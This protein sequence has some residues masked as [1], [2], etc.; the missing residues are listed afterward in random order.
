MFTQIDQLEQKH[1]VVVRDLNTQIENDNEY[2]TKLNKSLEKRIKILEE[3]EVKLLTEMDLLQVENT[4]YDKERRK[5]M[6]DIS[7]LMS[8]NNA[9]NRELSQF[10]MSSPTIS[11]NHNSQSTSD[12]F[13]DKSINSEADI[14]QLKKKLGKYKKDNKEL[15]DKTDEL[16]SELETLNYELAKLRGKDKE[17]TDPIGNDN[18]E[19]GDAK[20]K[21]SCCKELEASLEQMQRAYEDCEDYWYHK[22]KDER[23]LFEK[24]R[25]FFEDEQR[26]ADIK[27]TEL[28]EK[29]GEYEDQFKKDG[30]LSPIDERDLLEQQYLQMESEVEELRKN[31]P[32]ILDEKAKEMAVLQEQ[33]ANLQKHIE[34]PKDEEA[35]A[36]DVMDVDV[37]ANNGQAASIVCELCLRS[38]TES[39]APKEN[40]AANSPSDPMVSMDMEV[41]IHGLR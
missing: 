10:K 20:A 24:E 21:N 11:E 1:A 22:L 31:I 14:M 12:A 23:S 5:H 35:M 28:M 15:R 4:E 38:L 17:N 29:I 8:K 30:R 13:V 40:E 19:S 16:L 9:L 33:I 7:D 41:D 2:W 18:S 32:L 25:Q 6:K 36:V 26:Y 27:F 3:E 39:E 37:Y 34:E